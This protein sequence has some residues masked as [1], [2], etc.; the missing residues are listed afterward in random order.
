MLLMDG[1]R[2][3]AL[4][5]KHQTEATL[6]SNSLKMFSLKVPSLIKDGNGVT[7]FAGGDDVLALL[8]LENALATAIELRSAYLEAFADSEILQATI[9]GA[10]CV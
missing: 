10:R 6:I 3:G 2:L 5:Q 4:L 7:V 9:S 1:D 8:P